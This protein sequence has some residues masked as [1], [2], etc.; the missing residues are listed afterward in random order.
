MYCFINLLQDLES[1]FNIPSCPNCG[2]ILKPDVIFFGD[3]VPKQ[4]VDHVKSEVERCDSLLILGSSVST[5]S[6][7]RIVLQASKLSKPICIINIGD[8]RA[9][10]LAKLKID[11][12]CGQIIP[13]IIY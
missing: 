7:Y 10:H 11:T 12:R 8:T 9:D 13:N 6:A 2:G 4:R 5:F 3:N 1:S